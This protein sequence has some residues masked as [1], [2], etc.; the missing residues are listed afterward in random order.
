[1]N[2]P[3]NLLV[4]EASLADFLLLERQLRINGL[5]ANCQQVTTTADLAARLAVMD[6]DVVISDYHVPGMT[7]DTS[8]AMTRS[9]LP[10][11][12]FIVV[13]GTVGDEKAVE[14]LK[15]GISDFIL[16]DRLSRLAPTIRRALGDMLEQRA[17]QVVQCTLNEQNQIL[18]EMSALAH[19][20]GWEY[21]PVRGNIVWTEEMARIHEI[22]PGQDTSFTFILSFFHGPWR[23]KLKTALREAIE[24]GQAFDLE[25][26]LVTA[27]GTPKWVRMVVTPVS[28]RGVVV[29]LRGSTQDV[30][31]NKLNELLMFEQKERV[32]VTLHSIDDAVITT[33]AQGV[34]DYLNPAAERLTGWSMTMAFRQPLMQVL[35]IVGDDQTRLLL[36][37]ILSVLA[38]GASSHLPPHCLLVRPDGQR[39]AIEDSTAPIRSRDG[40]IIG[41]VLVFRDVTVA[42]A[43]AAQIAH[44]ALHDALTGLPNRLLAS[45]RLKQAI[46]AAQRNGMCV[47]VLFLDLDRF[48]NIND[49][50]GHSSG[51]YVLEQV[52]A[53]L[54]AV[55]RASD[56]VSRQGGD[57][58]MIIM[59][60]TSHQVH[61]SDMAKKILEVISA[62][63]LHQEQELN[64]TF[65]I[66]ISIYPFD[67][68]DASTL[69]KNADAAMY[70][71]KA[72]GRNNYKFYAAA[73][74]SK[75]AERLALEAQ[76]RHAVARHEFM[77]Y[78][79]PKI[80][81]AHRRLVGAEGLIRWQHPELGLLTPVNFIA[82]AEESG[83]IVPIGQ[84]VME[85]VC[86]QM[87][88]WRARG[89]DCVPVSVNLS[90]IQFRNKSLVDSLRQLLKKT[91][92]PPALF[93]LELTESVIMQNSDTVVQTLQRLKK[94]G[95]KLS[96]DDF[97]TGYSSLSY[98]KRFP[99]DAL[100][101]DQSFVRDIAHDDNDAAIIKAIIAMAHS[102]KLL[103]IAEG[104][105][106]EE[107]LTFLAT[108]HCDEMQGY[109]F[110]EPMLGSKFETLLGA[111]P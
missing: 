49:S 11:V 70:Y 9:V 73:M 19:I 95:I 34:I 58:F 39:A 84:W 101:I 23:Q 48:K 25:L 80:D 94:L 64:M 37:P 77:V 106:T 12:P 81:V 63:Y 98:L 86:Q 88:S 17:A 66:G 74:N 47:G 22:E 100:K 57:E 90:A 10:D 14:L 72:A 26:A 7:F 97:G 13:S 3:L 31:E 65:S 110:S 42:R 69:I 104:V 20:G 109:Y 21:D 89:L 61:F 8:L 67:G 59:P 35:H 93:E 52:A 4:I 108:H 87:Q 96:I 16:K 76:L 6:W 91:G 62:P 30:T 60:S 53:R 40:S 27:K 46:E 68:S 1:M 79:Q 107:Q 29:K 54:L 92:L 2:A 36:N 44:Q 18:R 28:V 103:V 75:A 55:T 82:I 24:F 78:Y 105:E 83:L 33:D 102:L 51:D 38:S 85:E 15:L 32:E 111:A 45:D 71:A 5:A 43:T 41:A 50:L 99:I 56:T